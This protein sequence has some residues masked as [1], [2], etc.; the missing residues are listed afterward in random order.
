MLLY[1]NHRKSNIENTY[2]HCSVLC[3]KFSNV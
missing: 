2:A 1:I 3:A